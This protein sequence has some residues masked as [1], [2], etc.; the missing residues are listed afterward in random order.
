MHPVVKSHLESFVSEHGLNTLDESKQFE[1][2]VNYCVLSQFYLGA[3]DP[4]QH[5]YSGDDPGIDGILFVLDGELIT[6]LAEVREILNKPKNDMEATICFIQ[7]KSGEGWQKKE[8]NTFES[9]IMDFLREDSLYPQDEFLKERK[10]IFTEIISKLRKIKNGKPNVYCYYATTG[11]YRG[12]NE[13]SAA[14]DSIKIQLEDAGYFHSIEVIPVDRDRLIDI[15]V[16]SYSPID[17]TISVIASASFPKSKGIEES[18]VVTLYAKEFLEKVLMDS[19]GVLRK[20][21]FEENVRDFLGSESDVNNE[22][23]GALGNDERRGRF[24]ILNNGITVISPDIRLQGTDLYMENFQIVNG[25]QTSNVLFENRDSV[26]EDVTLT[27]KIIETTDLEIVDEIVRATNNQNKVED[28]Q[29]LASLDV[30][31]NIQKYFMARG[32]EEDHRV[33]FARRHRQ[34][35][36]QGIPDIRV[37]DIREIARCVGAMFFDRPDLATRYPNQLTAELK[38]LVF[39]PNNREEIYYT[40]AFALY[41]LLL[42]IGNNRIPYKYRRFKWY[43]LM[44][45]KYEVG[46]AKIPRTDS[47]K[48]ETLCERIISVVDNNEDKN[49]ARILKCCE[50]IKDLGEVSNDRMKRQTLVEEAKDAILNK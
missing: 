42:H 6:S 32:T 3:I 26:T 5:I 35:S 23:G 14:I 8:I 16:S 43:L 40:A 47:S 19:N 4:S 1:A 27:V 9:A 38:S 12:E 28:Y 49:V 50:A 31:K 13:I 10:E 48:I 46:G 20:E 22:I 2:F 37:F 33:Y 29:F 41:R 39:N 25:C 45:L 11:R 30:V 24:G 7:S 15:W 21:I 34:Y 36:G 44:L 18:Y 17:C